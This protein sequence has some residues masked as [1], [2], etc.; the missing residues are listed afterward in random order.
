MQSTF[1]EVQKFNQVLIGLVS[2]P[3]ALFLVYALYK[4]LYLGE[5]FGSNPASDLGLVMIALLMFSL[6]PFFWG[7]KLETGINNEMI[8][9]RFFPFVNKTIIWNDVKSAEVH[10]YGFVGGWGI[11]LGTKYGTVYNISGNIGL[12]LELKS[13]KKILIG[14]QKEEELRKVI[15]QIGNF[16]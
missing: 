8:K 16:E 3:I 4:Q 13:G 14:T 7:M 1:H 5:P 6:I 12:A 9:I 10:K 11:R 15:S 2:I